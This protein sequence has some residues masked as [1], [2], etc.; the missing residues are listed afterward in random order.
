MPL[1]KEQGPKKKKK[2][3]K[4]QL[5]EKKLTILTNRINLRQNSK[6][7]DRVKMVLYHSWCPPLSWSWQR[8]PVPCPERRHGSEHSHQ[9]LQ[10]AAAGLLWDPPQETEQRSGE[11]CRWIAPQPGEGPE[12]VR[13][14]GSTW[15]THL[16]SN[17]NTEMGFVKF[18]VS[19]SYIESHKLYVKNICFIYM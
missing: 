18:Q 9:M 16:T 3:K 4:K 13:M 2:K 6:Q 19:Y 1:W 8:E 17:R 11:S 5:Q 7:K 10:P 15:V 12:K 14:D